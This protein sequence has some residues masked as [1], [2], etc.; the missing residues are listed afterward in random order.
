MALIWQSSPSQYPNKI[1]ADN[2]LPWHTSFGEEKDG[3]IREPPK[4]HKTLSSKLKRK[5][6]QVRWRAT[7]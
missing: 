7:L 4:S 2:T 5:E 6:L 3:L 1:I